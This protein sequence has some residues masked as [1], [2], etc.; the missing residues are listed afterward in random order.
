[1]G[2]IKKLISNEKRGV[3]IKNININIKI[4]DREENKKISEKIKKAK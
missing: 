1:M 2:S 4:K 3:K